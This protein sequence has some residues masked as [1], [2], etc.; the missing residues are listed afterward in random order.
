LLVS[1]SLFAQQ[2]QLSAEE[3]FDGSV[4][5]TD[6]VLRVQQWTKDKLFLGVADMR[7]STNRKMTIDLKKGKI[8]EDKTVAYATPATLTR[9][10]DALLKS[11][12]GAMNITYSPDSAYLAFTRD[13]DLYTLRISD[14]KEIRHTH[15]GSETLLNGRASWVYME[16]ILGRSTQYCAFWWSPDSRW[17][18]FFR[19]DDSQV[20]LYTVWDSPGQNGYIETLRYPKPENNLPI[21]KVGITKA[22][23]GEVIWAQVDE[24]E[25]FYFGLPYWRPDSKSLWLQWLN[26][27][28]QHYKLLETDIHTGKTTLLHSEQQDTWI[29]IDKEPRIHFLPSGKGFTFQSDANGWN[30]LYLHDMAGRRQHSITS[31][32]FT[33]LNVLKI[34]EPAKT[35]FFT[36]YKDNIGCEDFYRVGLDGKQLQRLSFGNYHHQIALSD[37]G[38]YFV[39]TYSNST[40]P[41]K[42]ALYTTKGKLVTELQNSKNANFDLYEWPVTEFITIKSADGKYDLPMRIIRPLYLEKEKVYPVKFNVYGGPGNVS[43]RNNWVNNFGG[44]SHQYAVDGLIQAVIDHRGSGHN[45]KQGQNEMYRNLGYW[46]IKDYSQCVQWLIAKQQADS[47]KI[48]ITGLSYGGYITAYALTYG[49]EVFTHGIAGLSVTDWRLYDAVYTERYMDTPANNPDGYKNSSVVN[50]AD[51]LEGK[52]LLTH[53]LR[54]ENVHVQNSFQFV[55]ALQDLGKDFELMIYPESRHGFRG[56]KAKYSRKSDI[57]FIYKYL[58]EKPILEEM[59]K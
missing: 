23:G 47:S 12:H 2:K 11:L 45:G 4:R 10:N 56:F 46:E 36:C 58:F 44:D 14:N 22:E 41:P 15:D 49:A 55:S 1:I 5:I 33:V 34:D 19:T 27:K 32:N 40:T 39:N 6:P 21:I 50:H 54:D 53:G 42:V 8:I 9:K 28:Q 51:R 20:P 17:L 37:D 24:N 3:M 57:Q 18:A 29:S 30:H 7:D 16:E 52:L 59:V 48:M 26:R 35:M 25:E 38:Q 13:N 43:V 31:G